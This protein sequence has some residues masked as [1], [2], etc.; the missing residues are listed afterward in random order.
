MWRDSNNSTLYLSAWS[1]S[2][3]ST[4]STVDTG[5]NA[6][7][8]STV[9]GGFH[10][11]YRAGNNLYI[12]HYVGAQVVDVPYAHKKQITT[13]NA[14]PNGPVTIA[15]GVDGIIVLWGASNTAPSVGGLYAK[16]VTLTGVVGSQAQINSDPG[17][18]DGGL[19]AVARSITH[20]GSALFVVYAAQSS[21]ATWIY[22]LYGTSINKSDV[23]YRS[24]MA[25]RAFTVGGEAFCWL[26]TL[27][28]N[29]H[30]LAG[31]IHPQVCGIADREDAL[32]RNINTNVQALA[33]VNPDP[34]D[35]YRYTW[36]RP[37]NVGTV[38]GANTSNGR[39]YSRPGNAR[40]GDMNFMPAL[41]AV[42]YGKSVYLAGSYCRNWDGITLGDCGFHDYPVVVNTSHSN[43]GSLSSGTYQFRV[44][45]VRYNAQGE[46]FQSAALTITV[47]SVATNDKVVLTIASLPVT[48]HDDVFYEVY[49]TTAGPS[50]TFYY[51]GAVAN[52]LTASTVTYTSTVSD[53]TLLTSGRLVDPFQTGVFNTSEIENWGP[54]GCEFF[55]VAGDRL[56]GAGGQIPP[57][58][59][60]FS[61]LHEDGFG[62]GFDDL[63]E[64]EEIDIQG[65]EIKSIVPWQE[66]VLAL[67][68]DRI[69]LIPG[70]GPNNYG[71]GSFDT[72]QLLVVD[73]A[74]NHVGTAMTQVGVVFWGDGGPRLLGSNFRVDNISLP[75]RALTKTLT[76]TGVQ[77]DLVRREVV[78]FTAEGSA[79]L[80]N[81]QGQIGRWAEWSGLNIAGC[82]SGALITTDGRVLVEQ[83]GIGDDGVPYP[84][85]GATGEL[86]PQDVLGGATHVYGVGIVG[87]HLGSHQLRMRVYFN[88]APYWTDQFTWEPES[89][90][91][92]ATAD[93]FVDG[94]GSQAPAAIDAL[95]AS[96]AGG[97]ATHKRVSRGDCRTF[98][99]EWSD[100]SAF[101]PTMTPFEI[102]VQLGE[103]GGFG[104]VAANTFGA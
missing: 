86:R 94:G 95:K 53:T 15:A 88:G 93:S 35:Q 20:N 70:A 69:Y 32:A 74:V 75:V 39:T 57:G 38:F 79:V 91:W 76:P 49:R 21:V 40:I 47:S 6:F 11:I 3:W 68:S 80:W 67:E 41:S 60:Q 19:S 16:R 46:R 13:T 96:H 52:T 27:N 34:L 104:R 56:W 24:V 102:S 89:N 103:R 63:A 37:Y 9:P 64:L 73:G 14:T 99:V 65:G 50:A 61:K 83:D 92:L 4:P 62:V 85:E 8:V 78:W 97:Y 25:S 42:Q 7:D 23:R 77:V 12:S 31:G 71:N 66:F 100:V 51:D 101:G 55:S 81:Y 10:L 98:K 59:A 82:S 5:V 28:S 45:A 2:A 48:N 33:M 87:Q 30:Y 18:Y 44:Y 17:V 29:T 1:G 22:E 58:F 72:P 90:T 84:F 36:V 26:R 54:L 43:G